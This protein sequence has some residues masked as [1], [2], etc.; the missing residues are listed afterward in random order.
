MPFIRPDLPYANQSLANDSRFRILTR[1]LEAPPTDIMLDSEFN[2]VTDG[3]NILEDTIAGIV[4]GQIPGAADPNNANFVLSTTGA[5]TQW[6]QISD[7]N[8]TP[9]SIDAN[10]LIPQ[11]VTNVQI[12]DGTI[13]SSKIA[14]DAI[15]TNKIFAGAVTTAKI[16]INAITSSELADNAVTTSAIANNAVTTLKILDANVTT[17]K[18]A[19][20]AVTTPIIL[21]ANVTTAKLAANAV[22]AAKMA[23]QT[24][25]ATQIA[26]QA[27][28]ATQIA[29]DTITFTQINNSF[30]ATKSQQQAAASSSV[31]VSPARQQD[32][33]SAASAWVTFDGTTGTILSSY[34]VS[35]VSKQSTGTFRITFTNA[36][37]NNAYA[38]FG[39]VQYTSP[40]VPI[41]DDAF[42]STT[43]QT[44]VKIYSPISPFNPGD[45][46]YVNC[47][48]YGTL[49]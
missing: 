16:A 28:T 29:N 9:Q 3:L 19:A 39:T 42:T 38:Q 33:P 8:I 7:I 27:I 25:T 18:L 1:S 13:G 34:N 45:C 49:A 44:Q 14:N 32:H 12:S 47:L 21:D 23:N 31:Y 15:T 6:I 10:K 43:S 48:F 36:F 5:A 24:I 37:S 2:A 20:N 17:A 46:T 40:R 30:T 35:T 26:N 4:L 41:F 22:T 11:S